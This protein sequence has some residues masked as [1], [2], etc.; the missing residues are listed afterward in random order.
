VLPARLDEDPRDRGPDAGGPDAG[1]GGLR[2]KALLIAPVLIALG[3]AAWQAWLEAGLLIVR[4]E[5]FG[6]LER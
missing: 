2:G 4:E 5:A 1:G 3:P 6:L